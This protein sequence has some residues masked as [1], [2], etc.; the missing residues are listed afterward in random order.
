[1][2]IVGFDAASPSIIVRPCVSVLENDT[3]TLKALKYAGTK[4]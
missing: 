2:Q 4:S 1:M 3:I